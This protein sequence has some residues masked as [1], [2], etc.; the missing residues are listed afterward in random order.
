MKLYQLTVEVTPEKE[1]EEEE[2]T[3]PSVDNMKQFQGRCGIA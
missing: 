3:I 2:V 1:E